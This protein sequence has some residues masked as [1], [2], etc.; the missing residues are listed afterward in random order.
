[1]PALVQTANG[2]WYRPLH[3]ELFDV[4]YDFPH[5]TYS[6]W[7]DQ[8]LL[9]ALGNE[10]AL[11]SLVRR[12]HRDAEV[13]SFPFLQPA[14]ATML[15]EEAR[16]FAAS[17]LHNPKP[18][19]MNNFGI[20]WNHIGMKPLFS[21][22][23]EA[24]LLPITRLLFPDIGGG[25]ADV[26]H[27]YLVHYDEQSDPQGLDM[28]HDSSDI[29]FNAA[30]SEPDSYTGS[31]LRFCGLHS[32]RS[33]RRHTFTYRHELGRAIL[34]DGRM[35]HAAEPIQSGERTNLVMWIHSTD[36][37]ATPAY[38]HHSVGTHP[39][40]S[41]SAEPQC[42]SYHHDTDY[43]SFR[44]PGHEMRCSEG[45]A[46]EYFWRWR[47]ALKEQSYWTVGTTFEAVEAAGGGLGDGQCAA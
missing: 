37:R 30:L 13:Y 6:A 28:H 40:G 31:G 47:R 22:L 44:L 7:F 35:R 18:N 2:E 14:F 24:V 19:G 39:N 25:S 43:C 38:A 5:H 34:Y 27:S 20:L 9:A 32:A 10:S 8:S 4:N 3:T 17:G 46:N 33:Y 29:T 45:G 1:M 41:G 21:R 16:H 11:R 36:F 42:V 15:L 23:L 12:E 26:H